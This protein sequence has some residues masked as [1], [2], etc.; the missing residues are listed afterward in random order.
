MS[1]LSDGFTNLV[2]TN[3]IFF[4]TKFAACFDLL[5]LGFMKTKLVKPS[6]EQIKSTI[7]LHKLRRINWL[8]FNYLFC[9]FVKNIP[10]LKFFGLNSQSGFFCVDIIVLLIILE[11]DI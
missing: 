3:P 4:P 5:K 7:E 10:L 11:M 2:F 8:I 9:L 6:H 1:C